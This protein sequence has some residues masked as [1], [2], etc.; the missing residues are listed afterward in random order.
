MRAYVK[1]VTSLK[2]KDYKPLILASITEDKIDRDITT[3]AIFL[4]NKK[5]EASLIVREQGILCGK[6]IFTEVFSIID[7]STKV[8][9]KFNDGD[10]VEAGNSVAL[11]KGD[12]KSMFQGE[13]IALNF[14]SMLS[15]IATKTHKA[16]EILRPFGI[17]A[18]DTRKTLPGYRLLSKYAVYTGGAAN[19]RL[20]LEQM[21]LIKDNHIA[22][23]GNIKKAIT[24]FRKMYPEHKCE[25]EVETTSQLKEALN[26]RP[27]M[28]MLD[29][30]N[31]REIKLCVEIMKQYNS[32]NQTNIICE[33]SGGYNLENIISLAHTGVDFVSMGSLTNSI[34][35]LDFSIEVCN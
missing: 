23:A 14:L 7:K 11:L 10:R 21:G 32:E 4:K 19:H 25:V 13:R 24:L 29:N 15:G 3:N 26:E 18:L 8:E 27:E 31:A 34:T 17:M 28:I 16:V 5:V 12:V 6:D 20:N 30:M 1:P 35:P 2:K 33:A 9:F 22:A